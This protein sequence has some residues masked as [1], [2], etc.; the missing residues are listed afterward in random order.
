MGRSVW[1]SGRMHGQLVGVGW[2]PP[3]LL[4]EAPRHWKGLRWGWLFIII[5]TAHTG[6]IGFRGAGTHQSNAGEGHIPIIIIIAVRLLS[7][8]TSNGQNQ[9]ASFFHSGSSSGSSF[10][11]PFSSA[12]SLTN[13]MHWLI[14]SL[15]MEAGPGGVVGMLADPLGAPSFYS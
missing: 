8:S 10:L 11:P 13:F 14:S 6:A 9:S 5:K 4:W 3:A 15:C 2:D 7:N 12:L 1:R